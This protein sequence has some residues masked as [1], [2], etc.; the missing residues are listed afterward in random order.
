MSVEPEVKIPVTIVTDVYFASGT[1][2]AGINQ[3]SAKRWRWRVWEVLGGQT[4]ESGITNG[5]RRARSMAVLKLA[6]YSDADPQ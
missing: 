2:R 1:I 5:V 4:I 3:I 6:A